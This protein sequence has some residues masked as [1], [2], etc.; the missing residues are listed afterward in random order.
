M[1]IRKMVAAVLVLSLSIQLHIKIRFNCWTSSRRNRT[2]LQ[3][4]RASTIFWKKKKITSSLSLSLSHSVMPSKERKKTKKRSRIEA[5]AAACRGFFW[6]T[7]SRSCKYR[8][9]TATTTRTKPCYSF[10]GTL[11][12]SS[13]PSPFFILLPGWAQFSLSQSGL[14]DT[15]YLGRM[16]GLLLKRFLFTYLLEPILSLSLSL[17]S[18]V[19]GF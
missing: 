12:K 4:V 2:Y 14:T 17:F 13:S 19:C 11:W 18:L 10:F 8:A 7:E 1:I 9:A 3:S 15:I 16:F 5:A 6:V